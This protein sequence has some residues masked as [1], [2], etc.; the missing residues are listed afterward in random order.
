M[1]KRET[2]RDPRR[3]H[4]LVVAPILIIA[5][6]AAC[7]SNPEERGATT[8]RDGGVQSDGSVASE[9]DAALVP[10]STA[11]PDGGGSLSGGP[12]AATLLTAPTI[13]LADQ[14][15]GE[16]VPTV[17]ETALIGVYWAFVVSN[18]QAGSLDPD[19][20]PIWPSGSGLGDCRRLSGLF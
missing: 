3:R 20:P 10:D 7:A 2:P 4:R 5:L 17:Q 15:S 11:P 1:S 19:R 12:K 18:S 8:L 6:A 9:S 13:A 16:H 14:A